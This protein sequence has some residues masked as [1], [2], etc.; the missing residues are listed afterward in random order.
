MT[1]Q[2]KTAIIIGGALILVG[3][4]TGG[5]LLARSTKNSSTE[6][7]VTVTP[8]AAAKPTAQYDLAELMAAAK[9]RFPT[10]TTTKVYTEETD[11]NNVMGKP[12]K[13]VAGAA[14]LDSRAGVTGEEWGADGGGGIEVY[15]TEEDAEKRVAYFNELVAS[16]SP[17]VSPGAY[18]Q[19]GVVVVR[20]SD[21]LAK[22]QQD[23]IIAFLAEKVQQ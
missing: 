20:A 15:K 5:W 2:A 17:L 10:V 21:A 16:G 4:G 11:P 6:V 14:F 1:F 9:A 13:Y 22:S 12:G 18:K 19:V 7:S 23:E 8:Q 3:I